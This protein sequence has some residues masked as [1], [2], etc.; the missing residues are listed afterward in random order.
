M[1]DKNH[2]INMV[3]LLLADRVTLP[4]VEG[5]WS[6]Q[7]L[8]T[9]ETSTEALKSGSQCHDLCCSRLLPQKLVDV[10]FVGTPYAWNK[11]RF[12]KLMKFHRCSGF[13]A[14][15]SPPQNGA[16][17]CCAGLLSIFLVA[18]RGLDPKD[19]LLLRLL[20]NLWCTSFKDKA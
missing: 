14:V 11:T 17:Q 18:P 7:I 4:I 9:T 20:G 5:E 12:G 6:S 1:F 13:P 2:F 15:F 19:L 3:M 8:S 10:C 16:I